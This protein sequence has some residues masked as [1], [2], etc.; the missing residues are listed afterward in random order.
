MNSEKRILTLTAGSHNL[1]HLFEGILPPLIPLLLVQFQTDYFHL[2]LA[3]SV[4]SIAFGAGAFPAGMISDRMP[5][6]HLIRMFLIGAGITSIWI[7]LIPTF[8]VFVILVGLSG[9]LC[10]I[11]H[12]ASNT[13]I[14]HTIALKGRAFGIHGIAGS[15]GVALAPGLSAWLAAISGWR[16][17]YI[18]YGVLGLALTVYS[19]TLHLSQTTPRSSPHST[20]VP[21]QPVDMVRLLLFYGSAAC[22]GLTY[23][24]ITTF[25]P[26]Y[27]GLRVDMASGFTNAVTWGGTMATT[28][29]L[30]GALGQYIGGRLVDR[31]SPEWIYL[32]SIAAGVITVIGLTI[33]T[34]LTIIVSAIL[35]AFF[36]FATQPIQNYMLA[37]YLPDHRHGIGYGIHFCLTFGVGALA[38]AVSGYL[39]D[40]FGLQSVFVFMTGCFLVSL[41]F[42]ILL[43]LR[44]QKTSRHFPSD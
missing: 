4:F 19:L 1:V 3:V 32:V 26:V 43:K 20:T 24:G 23:R 39:A 11:Y 35:Y 5:P 29:L 34:N 41:L 18:V 13:L 22:L 30:F 6:L 27:I 42:S 37:R 9:L 12:P 33:G 8:A 10:S 15:L 14:S 17:P 2:G 21:T 36:Y 25:L 40:R 16:L 31:I 28:A 7:A 44:A 38:A